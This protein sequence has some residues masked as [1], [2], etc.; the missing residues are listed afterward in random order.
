MLRKFARKIYLVEF[1]HCQNIFLRF[2][3]SLFHSNLNEKI[4]SNGQ[5]AKSNEQ[6]A[7][8]NKQREKSNEQRAKSNEQ[9][10]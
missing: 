9:R 7:K 4:T 1:R 5:G 10:A 3:V 2:T 8:S 6:R